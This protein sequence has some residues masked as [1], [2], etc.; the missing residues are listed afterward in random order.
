MQLIDIQQSSG[1]VLYSEY[2]RICTVV[3]DIMHP[4]GDTSPW[5]ICGLWNIPRRDWTSYNHQYVI[6]VAGCPLSCWYCYVDNLE[7]DLYMSASDIV[8][9]FEHMRNRA[10]EEYGWLEINVLHFM[11]G[12][13]GRYCEMWK[14]LR[15]EL[16][17]R[18]LDRIILFSD[19]IFLEDHFYS[20]KPWEHMNVSRLLVSGCMKAYN[21]LGFE[22]LTGHDLYYQ[23]CVERCNY[24]I[25]PNFY[26]TVVDWDEHELYSLSTYIPEERV[27]VLK[28]K[29][30]EVVKRRLGMKNGN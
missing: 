16:D 1:V 3:K 4:S 2:S 29:M 28:L 18:G 25:F 19:V 20:V 22:K 12:C 23:A 14:L 21:R 11:G 17:I 30:H 26:L 9:D 13:P 8:D 27:D 15:K 5:R 10:K 7:P 24:W 6:Q